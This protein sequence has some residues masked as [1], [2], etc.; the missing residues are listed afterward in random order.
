[1]KVIVSVGGKFHAFYLARELEKREVLA[2]LITSYPKFEVVKSGIPKEKIQSIVSK[3][4]LWRLWVKAPTFLKAFF[5]P[6][7]LVSNFFDRM[8]KRKIVPADIFTGWSSFSLY[9]MRKAKEMGMVAVIDHGSAH[10]EYHD[11][12]LREEKERW[13]IP[14]G[15]LKLAHPGIIAKEI[16]EYEEADAICIPSSFSKKTFLAAGVPEAKI[17]KIPYGVDIDEFRPGRKEDEVFRVVYAGGMTLQKGVHYLLR[18]FSELNLKNSELLLIGGLSKEISPFFEK[19]A[20]R[21]RY[22]GKVPQKELVR[23]YAQSSVF[24]LNSIHDGFGM[25]I[26]QAMA[27]GLPVIATENTGGPDII[28]EGKTGFIIPIRD[29]EKLKERLTFLY[30]NE[31]IRKEMGERAVRKA[32]SGFSWDDYGDNIFRAYEKLLEVQEKK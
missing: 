24:V 1:M 3:E 18:A 14:G 23:H 16:L 31:K 12:I 5:D 9:S 4:I 7:L 8:A 21:F 17:I 30:E 10:I 25:V 11:K 32:A 29:V 19:Y 6:N 20:G 27:S 2:R 15:R 22:L 28:E 26:I 13:G